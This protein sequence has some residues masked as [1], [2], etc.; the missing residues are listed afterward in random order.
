MI[1]DS[2]PLDRY[3][4][5]IHRRGLTIYDHI[6]I[7]DPSLW[8]PTPDLQVLLYDGLIGISL[9]GMPLRTRSK[10]VKGQICRVLGY[11]IPR[12]FRRT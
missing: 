9:E 3:V 7:S 11:P 8:I 4:A 5:A 2:G 12:S 1:E 6:E 10:V